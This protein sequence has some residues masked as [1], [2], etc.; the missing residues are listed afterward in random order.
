MAA[1]LATVVRYVL[2]SVTTVTVVSALSTL[3][4]GLAM[5]YCFALLSSAVYYKTDFCTKCPALNRLTIYNDIHTSVIL[6]LG[7]QLNHI[8]SP[9]DPTYAEPQLPGRTLVKTP[10]TEE[11]ALQSPPPVPP[12]TRDI[13]VC[14]C[15]EW[16]M[17]TYM[18]NQVVMTIT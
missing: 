1:Y 16:R 5:V 11:Q 18:I 13:L 3:V 4:T 10:S 8:Q 14:T 7:E 9:P 12:I 6:L 2:L 15:R 17:L